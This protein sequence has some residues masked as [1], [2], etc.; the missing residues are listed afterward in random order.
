MELSLPCPHCRTEKVGF[1]VVAEHQ[2]KADT[3]RFDVFAYCRA[4]ESSVVVEAQS[5]G[6]TGSVLVDWTAD[7]GHVSL[8][9][10]HPHWNTTSTSAPEHTPDPIAKDFVEGLECLRRGSFNAAGMMFRKTLQRATTAIADGAGI[11]PFKSKTPLQHR[12]D[13]LAEHNLLTESMRDLAV[14]VKLDGNAAAHEEEQEFDKAAATQTK[15]FVELF[16]LYTLSLP[17]RVKRASP[18][19]Q[20]IKSH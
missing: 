19:G 4:C 1:C 11:G 15:E 2:H 3:E 14:A 16:L 7:P 6:A 13:A 20:P 9:R 17:E 12:I 10:M 8:K 5:S 18:G